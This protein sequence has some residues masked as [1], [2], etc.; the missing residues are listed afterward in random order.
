MNDNSSKK[1]LVF[2]ARQ[3]L[4]NYFTVLKQAVLSF[5]NLVKKT[6]LWKTLLLSVLSTISFQN[7]KPKYKFK[8]KTF[9]TLNKTEWK[10]LPSSWAVIPAN[11]K[12]HW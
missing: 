11:I 4:G 9:Q 6:R 10:T 7:N 2:I 1:S 12:Y 3:A 5:P 8:Y